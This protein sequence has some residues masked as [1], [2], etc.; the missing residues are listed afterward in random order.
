MVVFVGSAGCPYLVE[1]D[2]IFCN[3]RGSAYLRFHD[4][5]GRI[6]G[7]GRSYIS[8]NLFAGE[9]ELC[10]V[11]SIE[12]LND[13]EVVETYAAHGIVDPLP[14]AGSGELGVMGASGQGAPLPPATGEPADSETGA[15]WTL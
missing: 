5:D 3:L 4:L 11:R 14:P 10:Q 8:G 7:L 15:E 2:G 9:D 13:D 1:V 6:C 12:P